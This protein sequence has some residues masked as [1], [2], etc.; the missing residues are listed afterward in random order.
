MPGVNLGLQ[1]LSAGTSLLPDISVV[2]PKKVIGTNTVEAMRSGAVFATASMIDGMAE[3]M[4]AELGEPCRVIAT[5]GLA[6]IITGC[7]RRQILY[8]SQL[9][10]KGLWVLWERNRKE[11]NAEKR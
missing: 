6:K 3:R 9:L 5:G 10:L 2:E 1:A 8:D 4:E 7:C 11:K